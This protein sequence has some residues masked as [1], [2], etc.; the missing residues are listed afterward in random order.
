MSQSTLS[1]CHCPAQGVHCWNSDL[2]WL[3]LKI[4]IQGWYAL[5][6]VPTV[7][8]LPAIA[9]HFTAD[10]ESD[11]CLLFFF[12]QSLLSSEPFSC[13]NWTHSPTSTIGHTHHT[14]P[15]LA[16]K[17]DPCCLCVALFEEDQAV[18]CLSLGCSCQL[19]AA[20]ASCSR[21]A[22]ALT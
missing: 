15:L 22:H 11:I 19:T 5:F 8:N 9:S 17:P 20:L 2:F 1:N 16:G 12:L 14:G 6:E 13:V 7:D 18:W 3:L 21:T 4:L 10:D